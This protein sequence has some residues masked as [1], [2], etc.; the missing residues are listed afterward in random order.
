MTY[1]KYVLLVNCY[2]KLV[3]HER[4]FGWNEEIS[5]RLARLRRAI[6]SAPQHVIE[7]LSLNE[8]ILHGR[9]R[10]LENDLDDSD[11]FDEDEDWE[12]AR[13]NRPRRGEADRLER[14]E[15]LQTLMT[16]VPTNSLPETDRDC[17]ICGDSFGFGM[18]GKEA[19][20]AAQ[21]PCCHV[22]VWVG[23]L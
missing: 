6:I 9:V 8:Q 12:E 23:K 22:G 16:S 14:I 2:R 17:A 3:F 18:E 10:R 20:D 4:N 11:N 15:A 13:T 21:L 1:Q 19:E 7:Q 5:D